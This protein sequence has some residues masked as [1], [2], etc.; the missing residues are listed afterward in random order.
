MALKDFLIMVITFTG[1]EGLTWLIHKYVMHGFL[2]YLHKDH[3]DHSRKG[4]V[5]RND[6]FFIIFATPAIL[7]ML[8]GAKQGF[9]ASF[10]IGCGISLYGFTYFF[11]HDVFIHQRIPI[12]KNTKNPYL[13]A[14]RRAHKQHHKH[15]SKKPGECYGFLWVPLKYFI[16][17]FRNKKL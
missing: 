2:W 8:D 9:N 6:Y 15:I 12:L 14:I 3:H 10:F 5:E 7:L 13:L 4:S 1:M 17:Y 16:M 11:V